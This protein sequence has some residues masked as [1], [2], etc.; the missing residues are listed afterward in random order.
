[1]MLL[2]KTCF[3]G[4]TQ[5]GNIE[6][7]ASLSTI[8]G[9]TLA[10]DHIVVPSNMVSTNLLE[11]PQEEDEPFKIKFL[12]LTLMKRSMS[13]YLPRKEGTVYFLIKAKKSPF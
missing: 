3:P 6:I 8:K 5:N 1:M 2:L 12:Q 7:K 4:I 9:K 13:K 11:L 10:S